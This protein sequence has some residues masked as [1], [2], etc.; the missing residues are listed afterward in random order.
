M[1]IKEVVK[2]LQIIK[3]ETQAEFGDF[4]DE[5]LRWKP[6][7]HSWSIAECLKH[8]IIANDMYLTDINHKLEKAEVRT[9]EYP[10]KI[11]WMGR[12]FLFF[13]D[14]K[15]T[16]KIP[17]PKLFKPIHQN[18]V[19][20][21]RETLKHYLQLQDDIIKTAEKALGYDHANIYTTSPLSKLLRFNI[22]EQFYIMMRHEL[23]H[24]NQAKRVKRL[25]G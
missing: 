8:I 3:D 10:I 2:E 19:A 7:A 12:I 21:G 17:A 22:G 11:S 1:W 16:W 25:M 6:D 13:V 4:S 24:L 20:D 5:Q 15:Y 14:P 23:R 9:I 18:E